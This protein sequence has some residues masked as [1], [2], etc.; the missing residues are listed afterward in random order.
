LPD[1]A[2][3]ETVLTNAN[4][5]LLASL[6]GRRILVVGDLFLDEYLVGKATR[7]SREA[8]IPVLEF[9]HRFTLPGGAA[10]PAHNIAALGG[11]ALQVG[12]VGKDAAGRLLLRH[13]RRVGVGIEGV[14][15]DPSRST[16]TKTRLMAQGFLRFPQQVARLDRLD[17][18]PLDTTV[19]AALL[20]YLTRAIP[21]VDAVL[22]SDYKVGIVNEEVVAVCLSTA[23]R[24]GKLVTVD[25]QGD[26][27]KFSGCDLVKC[28]AAEAQAALNRPLIREA[29]FRQA[30]ALLLE[31]LGARYIVITRGAEGMSLQGRDVPYACLP[32]ANRSEVYD[33]TGAGDTVIAVLTLGLAA[34]ADLVTAARLAN[35]AAGLVVRKL[36]N[37]VVTPQ[38][39]QAALRM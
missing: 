31:S 26:L 33:V 10:N 6:A 8:P 14:V 19:Q 9:V 7:L 3:E 18:R 29:D 35:V 17:R 20:D 22:L 12:V 30:T 34:G 13:L 11:I 38:E 24:H 37:A 21:T 39:L 15:T 2:F 4:S 32:A 25:S 16:T 1:H 27:A 23:R 36:G 5:L 28:N